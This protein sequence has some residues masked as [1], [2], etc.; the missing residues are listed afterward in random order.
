MRNTFW[1]ASQVAG[2]P[3]ELGLAVDE[4]RARDDLAVDE[5]IG[6]GHGV[7][8]VMQIDVTVT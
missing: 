1:P 4:G 3:I 2:Q 8:S 6:R 7:R 5:G